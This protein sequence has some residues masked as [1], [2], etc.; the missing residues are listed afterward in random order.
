M[1]SSESLR[2]I[3]RYLNTTGIEPR[4]FA[5]RRR[6]FR[7]IYYARK[8]CRRTPLTVAA[9]EMLRPYLAKRWYVLLWILHRV[10][11]PTENLLRFLN[12]VPRNR[13]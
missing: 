5:M 2:I 13:S 11:K 10:T 8:D 1:A 4:S 7:H 12:K 3:S 9:E 6:L